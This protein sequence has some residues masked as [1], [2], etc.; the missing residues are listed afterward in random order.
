MTGASAAGAGLPITVFTPTFNRAHTLGRLHASLLAQKS[1]RFEWLVV[2][3]GSTDDTQELLARL[4]RSSPFVVRV[5]TQENAGKHTAHNRAVSIAAGELTIVLDSDDELVPGALETLWSEWRGISESERGGYSGIAANSVDED[6]RI[7]GRPFPRDRIDGHFL[8]LV[9]DGTLVGDKLP[10]YRTDVLRSFPF[11][12]EARGESIPEGTVW[13]R[14]GFHYLLRC[15]NRTVLL[16]HRPGDDANSL[17]S[18]VKAPGASAFGRRLYALTVLEQARG[19]LLAHPVFLAR[20]AVIVVRAS[21]H[22]GEGLREQLRIL[23]NAQSRA[24]LL[25]AFPVG[26][27]AWLSDRRKMKER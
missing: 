19:R 16:V 13:S 26:A 27:A 14:I 6:G 9:A 22:L 11:P 7:I 1:E 3:D 23:P 24:L 8:E 10:C 4:A 21:L 5:I 15:V 12:S 2:D 20:H 17:M 18:R 25:A